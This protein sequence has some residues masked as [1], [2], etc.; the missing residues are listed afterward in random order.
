MLCAP[1]SHSN[2]S[3]LD[4]ILVKFSQLYYQDI[5]AQAC[6]N[7]EELS[8]IAAEASKMDLA[9]SHWASSQM[10]IWKP[11]PRGSLS[12]EVAAQSS[13]ELGHSGHVDEYYNRK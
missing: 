6:P 5:L 13:Y 3:A 8:Q 2:L 11:V 7:L 9:F 1:V 12:Q 10:D 4:Q